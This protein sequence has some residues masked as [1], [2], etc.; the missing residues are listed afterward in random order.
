MNQ[1]KS[2]HHNY[3]QNE[4]QFICFDR[5]GVFPGGQSSTGGINCKYGL[6][7]QGYNKQTHFFCHLF[8]YILYIDYFHC[9][10]SFHLV[11]DSQTSLSAEDK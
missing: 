10:V 7:H 9:V 6:N 4:K 11:A 1:I 2:N 3:D 5:R 8:L